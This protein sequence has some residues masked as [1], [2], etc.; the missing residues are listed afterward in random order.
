MPEK[1]KKTA[2]KKSIKKKHA[3]ADSYAINHYYMDISRRYKTA[4]FLTVFILIVFVLGM[5]A[6]NRDD[7]TVEG[8]QYLMRYLDIDSNIYSYT[9][10]SIK[11]SYSTDKEIN[12]DEFRGDFVIADSTAVNIY[13]LSGMNILSESS[14]ISNPVIRSSGRHLLVYDLGGNSYALYNSFSKLYGET[15]PYPITGAANSDDGLYA[16]VTKTQEYRSAVYIYNRK[17]ELISRILKDKLVMDV[18]IKPDGSSILIVSAFNLDGDFQTEIMTCDPFSDSAAVL[19]THE[20]LMPLRAH[21]YEDGFTVLCDNKL[22]FYTD[23]GILK[24]QYGYNGDIPA[25]SLITDD[26]AFIAF[27]ENVVG[28]AHRLLI[29]DSNGIQTGEQTIDGQIIKLLCVENNLF[30]LTATN[31][32]KTEMNGSSAETYPIEKNSIDLIAADNNTL[33]LCYPSYAVSINISSA[34]S[35]VQTT[36]AATETYKTS[37]TT[38]LQP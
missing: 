20:D 12:F 8:F 17:H 32:I 24:N 16:L 34:F 31:I 25:Y 2:Q 13:S 11:I 5:M 15:L 28:D 6:A 26:H 35:K 14:F 36:D 19:I 21:Y 10:D 38:A 33:F 3:G 18:S 9:S 30:V 4:K 1:E 37:E 27:S 22:L 23:G 29:F 7:I